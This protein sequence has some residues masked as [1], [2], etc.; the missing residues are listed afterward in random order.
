[1]PKIKSNKLADN[2]PDIENK[3]I[4]DYRLWYLG[5]PK[6]VDNYNNYCWVYIKLIY[7]ASSVPLA[8]PTPLRSRIRR[9]STLPWYTKTCNI[10]TQIQIHNADNNAHWY[11]LFITFLLWFRITGKRITRKRS[12]QLQLL[13]ISS[14]IYMNYVVI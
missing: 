2:Y 7:H 10:A 13:F 8:I 14:K 6:S 3:I 11:L 9:I 4:V 12:K 5:R 1:M